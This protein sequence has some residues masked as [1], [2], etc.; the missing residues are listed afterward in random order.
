MA[1]TIVR[2]ACFRCG[3]EKN[4][5][6]NHSL[7]RGECRACR[8]SRAPQQTCTGCGRQR[9]INARTPDGGALCVTCYAR[10]RTGDDG[11]EE[12]GAIGPLAARAGGKGEAS[13]NLCT[14]CYRNPRRPC[15]ICG[16]L[17][18]IALKATATSPDVCPTC[19]QAPVI[20][21]SICGQQ[22]LGRRTTNN[23]RPRCFACQATAQIDAALTGPNGLI[24]PELLPVRDALTA[25][26]RPRSLLT[27]WHDLA[28]LHLLAEIAQGQLGLTH[29]ALDARPQTFSVTYLR[30]MLVA[31]DALP[32]RDENAARLH[33]Y[34]AH[35]VAGVDDP[36]LRGVLTR[37]ARWHVVGRAKTNRHG[38]ISTATA[39]RCRRDIQTAKAFI[40]HLTAHHHDLD[41]CPQSC[42]DAWITVDRSRR[43]GFIRW[44]KRGGYLPRT[45][46][47]EPVPGKDPRHDIDPCQQLDLARRLLHDAD[48]ASIEDRAAACLVL[49]YAQPITKIVTLT[50]ADIRAAAGDTYLTLGREPLLLL[51]PLDALI[52]ALPETK[53][54][55]TASALADPRWLFSGKNAG[56]HLQ[57][58]SLMARMNR[59]G[60]TTRAS[61]NTAMLHLASTT[62]P[63]VFAHLI[64]VSL[65]TATRWTELSGAIWNTYAT[66]RS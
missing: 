2:G 41:N 11:C 58:P 25:T 30:A 10:T 12:C 23:G 37:Y 31:A 60:I 15:G 8:A 43:L 24:R 52:T 48:S 62:P 27:N 55:G 26:S 7:D 5:R 45:R 47:P 57:P 49:L 63:A 39:D 17:K 42:L 36:E 32:P 53:Q 66:T 20:D 61:R 16:R 50:T 14:R 51:P 44:L 21:C 18:R 19:Y 65:G 56:T 34:A 40:D 35:A 28:S 33:R 13:R 22:A 9:R 4:L 54:F 64:G 1:S 3:R 6:W 46:L 38:E 59:L 29:D